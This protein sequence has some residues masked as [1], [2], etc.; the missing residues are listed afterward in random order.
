MAKQQHKDRAHALLS[1]SGAERWINCTPSARLEEQVPSKGASV[2]ADEGT[3][4][5]EL[6]ENRLLNYLTKRPTVE[7][8]LIDVRYNQLKAKEWYSEETEVYV[9]TYVDYVIELHKQYPNSSLLI[10]KKINLGNIIEGGFGTNDAVIVADNRIIVID[11]KFGQGNI[12]SAEDNSQLKLYAYGSFRANELNFEIDEDSIVELVIVQPRRDHVS[13]Y[14]LSAKELIE[15][16]EGYVKERAAMAHK[17]QGEC[18]AGSWCKWCKVAAQCRT[19]AEFCS[20]AAVEDF[21][22]QSKLLTPDEIAEYL[23]RREIIRNWLSALEVYALE[24]ALEGV[25]WP[26]YKVVESRTN[27]KWA[28]DEA[29][30]AKLKEKGFTP[31]Q[32]YQT[33]LQGIGAIEKLVG[34]KEFPALLNDLVVKPEG[35]PTLVE[36]SD[37]REAYSLNSAESDFGEVLE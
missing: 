3:F 18:A 14:E 33:K 31:E 36:I 22:E 7:S 2:Y 9:D 37:K 21:A 8:K 13:H 12:V 5:H 17:G 25:E 28:D 35:K 23:N 19:N 32:I 26:G 30:A 24:Q 6:A 15:W 27:R 11:L 29:V 16:A 20:A 34:K 1:A 4:A 10:E